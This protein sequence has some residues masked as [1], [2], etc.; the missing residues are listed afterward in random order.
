[1]QL[2]L[3]S[4]WPETEQLQIP[5]TQEEPE[6]QALPHVPQSAPFAGPLQVPSGISS[7]TCRSTSRSPCCRRRRRSRTPCNWCRSVRGSTG[8]R[9]PH[10][11]RSRPCKRRNP[12]CRCCRS[13]RP[14]R[15]SRSSGCRSAGCGGCA[16]AFDRSH[17]EIPF[18][19]T[20]RASA[21][22]TTPATRPGADQENKRVLWGASFI[23]SQTGAPRPA[24]PRPS[25]SDSHGPS[26]QALSFSGKDIAPKLTTLAS[27][28]FHW[29]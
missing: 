19:R 27:S 9:C 10:S 13:R 18:P 21:A 20:R 16:P 29:S 25:Q 11:S 14:C 23:L 17:R 1:M 8:R 24:G 2:P 26:G 7:P 4:C 5:L 3:H 6:P 28:M 15:T 22:C 12:P